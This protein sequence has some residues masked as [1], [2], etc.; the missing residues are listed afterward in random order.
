MEVYNSYANLLLS[1]ID[2]HNNI[3]KEYRD[4]LEFNTY[5]ALLELSSYYYPTSKISEEYN[6]IENF[7]RRL[8]NLKVKIQLKRR[9]SEI[10]TLIEQL[11]EEYKKIKK[12]I[13][14]YNKNNLNVANIIKEKNPQ[15]LTTLID[16]LTI[17]KMSLDSKK[18]E[19]DNIRNIITK[20]HE[21][22]TY[23]YSENIIHITENNNIVLEIQFQEFKE[24]FSYLLEIDSYKDVYKDE[25]SNNLHKKVIE[26]LIN[27]K[28]EKSIIPLTITY[29]FNQENIPY[30]DL[31]TS[32]FNIENIKIS[33][34][35]SFG[36]RERKIKNARW[37][38]ISISNEFLYPKLILLTKK[39]MYYQE[40][41]S[42]IFEDTN[43]E[44]KVS[45]NNKDITNFLKEILE[46]IIDN[47][48]KTR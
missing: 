38:N 11:L 13:L 27:K 4:Y 14:K 47:K 17:E 45:I 26:S 16:A 33:D 28:Y 12:S 23:D 30:N 21:N 43:N 10:D 20:K 29:I 42:I 37:K 39:G 44:F 7:L 48:T 9:Q 18:K 6:S 36:T 40:N 22:I 1:L 2:N 3:P 25:N 19:Y 41:D 31:D 46:I 35:N 8:N 15:D 32:A 34:L 24:I 5:L